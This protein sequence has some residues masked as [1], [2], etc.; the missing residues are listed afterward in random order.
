[1]SLLSTPTARPERVFSL[2]SLIR[3]L[4]GRVKQTE[5]IAC[6][7][8]QYRSAENAPAKD[9]DRV[10]EVFRV[11]KSLGLLY[12]DKDYWVNNGE[13]PAT[14]RQLARHVHAY[15]C[16]LPKDDPDAVPLRAYA[17]CVAS[18]EQF[19]TANLLD[20]GPQAIANEISEALGRAED[21][22][23]ERVFNSTKLSAWKDWMIFLGLGWNDL[24]GTKGFLPDPSRRIA[25]ELLALNGSRSRV[26]GEAFIAAVA[27]G[28]PYLD[29][30][31]LFREACDTRGV[32]PSKGLISRLLSQALRILESDGVLKFDIEGDTKKGVALFQDPLSAHQFFSHL[33]FPWKPGHV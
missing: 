25:E 20:K 11:A 32:H 7:A 23:E 9:G 5:A 6:L 19:G 1:M 24:P 18:I 4:D 21:G 16:G 2:V 26:E 3:A 30:G 31:A 15:L 8:P 28:L 14:R 22:D 10:R 29:G 33:D 27:K 12:D 17:W 13:I